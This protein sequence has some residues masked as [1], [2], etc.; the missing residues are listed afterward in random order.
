MSA[1]SSG[2]LAVSS[3]AYIESGIQLIAKSFC[4]EVPDSVAACLNLT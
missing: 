4:H 1:N 2:D 3:A